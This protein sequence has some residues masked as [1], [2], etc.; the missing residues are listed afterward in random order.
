M[1]EDATPASLPYFK[2]TKIIF[3]ILFA[4]VILQAIYA[5]VNIG[6][7]MSIPSSSVQLVNTGSSYYTE[8][9]IGYMNLSFSYLGFKKAVTNPRLFLITSSLLI[10][11]MHSL[12][13]LALMNYGRKLFKTFTHSY[14]P[15]TL[16]AATLIK[17]MG[18]TMLFMGAFCK[19]IFQLSLSIIL[20]QQ[21]SFINPYELNWLF[22][23]AITLLLASIFSRGCLLQQE[24][25][26]TL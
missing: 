4:G 23:G 6:Y 17:K 19:L 11:L 25:D 8:G 7:F 15:F 21:P 12:P 24:A 10:F 18:Y 2:T 20:F 9:P 3:V 1:N 14:T 5:L 26:T 13:L 16:E 22:T